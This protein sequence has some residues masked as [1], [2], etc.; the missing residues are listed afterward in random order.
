MCVL[1]KKIF[2]V[3]T[4]VSWYYGNSQSEKAKLISYWHFVLK[5][6]NSCKIFYLESLFLIRYLVGF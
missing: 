4:P 3:G 5:E 2:D 1:Q 6:E